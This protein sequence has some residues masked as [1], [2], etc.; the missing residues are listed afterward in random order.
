MVAISLGAN[1]QDKNYMF[2]KF[3]HEC[4]FDADV[5]KVLCS[6]FL[7]SIFFTVSYEAKT[8]FSYDLLLEPVTSIH[9]QKKGQRRTTYILYFQKLIKY[10]FFPATAIWYTKECL[11]CFLFCFVFLSVVVLCFLKPSH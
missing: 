11:G 5:N 9:Q 10:E 4:D 2:S 6:E 1:Q 7:N 8:D 3:T